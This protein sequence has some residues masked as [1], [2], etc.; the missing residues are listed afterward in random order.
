MSMFILCGIARASALNESNEKC[1]ITVKIT[2]A[3]IPFVSKFCQAEFLGFQ[4]LLI[5][6]P[7]FW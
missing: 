4:G 6:P 7:I 5:V 1:M 2:I 3:D